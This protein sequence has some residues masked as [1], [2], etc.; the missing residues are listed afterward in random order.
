MILICRCSNSKN[1]L[2]EAALMRILIYLSL[3]FMLEGCSSGGKRDHEDDNNSREASECIE[4]EAVM[5]APTNI[6]LE[7]AAASVVVRCSTYTDA[8]RR[9]LNGEYPGYRDYIA[10]KLREV[11]ELYLAQARL[12]VARARQPK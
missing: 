10:P 1:S 7:A 6:D 11:D 12:A 4:R 3:L 2:Q 8:L 5:V 9:K